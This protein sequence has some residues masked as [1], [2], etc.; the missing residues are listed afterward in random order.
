[1]KEFSPIKEMF[2]L[3]FFLGVF[4][5]F[6]FTQVTWSYDQRIWDPGISYSWRN[7]ES[8]QE[9]PPWCV[10]VG[11]IEDDGQSQVRFLL[12]KS[13]YWVFRN[14]NCG[15]IM[16]MQPQKNMR[17]WFQAEDTFLFVCGCWYNH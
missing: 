10:T 16:V 4:Q 12:E 1:M 14:Q 15:L 9:E 7:N 13:V 8:V 17:R 3:W 6:D 11:E 5:C 2:H